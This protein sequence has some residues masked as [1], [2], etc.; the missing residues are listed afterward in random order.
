MDLHRRELINFEDS[1]ALQLAQLQQHVRNHQPEHQQDGP[2]LAVLIERIQ[3]M[4]MLSKMID[5]A[6]RLLGE[7][8]QATAQMAAAAYWAERGQQD[9]PAN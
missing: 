9:P 8:A 1:F 6:A 5:R 3:N 4:L 2:D 7:Q